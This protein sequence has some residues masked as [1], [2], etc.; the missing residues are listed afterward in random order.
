MKKIFVMFLLTFCLY[1]NQV[2]VGCEGNFYQ[3]NGSV[4]ILNDGVPYEYSDNPI[5]AIVQSLY[6]ND[7]QLFVTV[8]G[9]H[10]IEIFNIEEYS[11]EHILSIDTNSS[12]PREMFVY[13]D[14]LYFSNWYSADVKVVDLNS[15][16]IVDEIQM[17]GLPEDIVL[18]N[19]LLYVSITMNYDWTDGDKVVSINPE[20]NEIV[21]T[22]DVGSGPG[23]MIVHDDEVYISRTYYDDNWNAYYGTSKINDLGEVILAE[24]GGGTACGGSV[25]SYQ[26]N[27]YRAYNGGIAKLDENL[28]ILPETRIG[29]FSPEDIYSVEVIGDNIYFGLTDFNAPDEVVVLD[30][31]GNIVEE[32]S[33]GVAPGDFAF[34]E[35]CEATGDLNN[36]NDLNVFDIIIAVSSI[37]NNN[38]FDCKADFN[39]DGIVNIIDVVEMVQEIFNIDSFFGAVN[40]ID[41]HFPSLK[42]IDKLQAP[43]YTK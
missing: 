20:N 15:W 4:W 33:V 24:Y 8:N 40:W 31:L 35:P 1:A 21:S 6:V 9:S 2:F 10:S 26:N 34:W 36:D 28:E 11:L 17:P 12:S 25:H 16:E 29:N 23:D 18:L 39:Q 30:A 3:S 42:I 22:Y 19:D 27:I 41:R 13:G 43:Q 5:G 7:N 37:I 32:Y 38:D 14:K